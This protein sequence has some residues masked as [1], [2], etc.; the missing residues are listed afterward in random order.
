[1]NDTVPKPQVRAESISCEHSRALFERAR[2]V[3]PGGNSRHSVFFAPHPPYAVSGQGARVIDAD[4][5]ERIDFLNN[6]SSLIHGHGHP[7]V[8]RALHAQADRMLAVG[9]PTE[10]E[11]ELA[12]LLCQRVT[13]IEQVR[14]TNSG[15]EAVMMA[16]KAARAYTGR[17]AIAKFE[18]CYH[19]T[20]DPVEVSQ[21]PPSDR[22]GSATEPASVPLSAGTPEGLVQDTIVLPF[23]DVPAATRILAKHATHLAGVLIDLTPAH[24]G[25]MQISRPML[26]MLRDFADAHGVLLIL[27]EVYSLRLD[28]RGGQHLFDVRPDITVMGKIIGGGLPIGA[29]GAS[30]RIMSVFDPAP[31]GPAV[32]HGGTY[33]ANPLSMATG[34]ASM[35]A[36]TPASLATLDQLGDDLRQELRALARQRRAELVIEG[37]GSLVSFTFG[38]P[39][40]RNYRDRIAQSSHRGKLE[41]FHH[42]MMEG[43]ILLAP[44]GLAVLSTPMGKAEIEAF[45]S[46]ADAALRELA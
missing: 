21:A 42:R 2:A 43:G 11:V 4:G 12:E 45:L 9:L 8:I 1:M 32:M 27:D 19:G 6:F 30:A 44:Q 28:F 7:E 46:A 23:D 35:R 20:Y 26:A 15:T 31:P 16:V 5:V 36:L 38:R 3:L 34:L 40:L 18:G 13:S 24:L 33:N 25:Y 10:Q 29:V 39:P 22:W 17:P 41:Q 37:L 14:F